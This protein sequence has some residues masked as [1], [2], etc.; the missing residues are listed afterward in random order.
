MFNLIAIA[1]RRLASLS[2]VVALSA[3]VTGPVLAQ[4]NPSNAFLYRV[5]LEL[6]SG[7]SAPGA[8]NA[9]PV[10]VTFSDLVVGNA[11]SVAVL[12][13]NSGAQALSIG[14]I[15]YAGGP[16]FIVDSSSCP[17]SLAAGQSCALG[18]T[19]APIARAIFNEA[20]LI[21]HSAG[22]TQVGL[23]GR[24]LQGALQASSANLS[25]DPVVVP[26]GSAST[27]QV[28]LTNVGDAAVGSITLNAEA[29][30]SIS[31]SCAT[32]GAGGTCDVSLQFSPTTA[33]SFSGA[34]Q[35]SSPVGNLSTGLSGQGVA[36]TSV[37]QLTGAAAIDF[38]A[39][40]LGASAV[41][42]T[43]SIRNDGNTGLSISGVSGL[44][45]SVSITSNS[46]TNV[47]PG[48][49]CA[50]VLTLS[51]A[52]M[53]S[54][55]NQAAQSVGASTN[56]SVSLTGSVTAS[57][58]TR[59]SG[60][61]VDFGSA[62]QNA[63][64]VDRT[65]TLRNDGNVPMTL[66]GISGLPGAVSVAS[67]GCSTVAPAAQCVIGLR[68]ATTGAI[69][70][71]SGTGTTQG[72]STNATVSVTGAITS[73][74]ADYTTLN[75]SWFSNR[76]VTSSINTAQEHAGNARFTIT[77]NGQTFTQS[78]YIRCGSDGCDANSYNDLFSEPSAGGMGH[79]GSSLLYQLRTAFPTWTISNVNAYTI[80]IN[81]PAGVSYTVS[82]S[83]FE[84]RYGTGANLS[85]NIGITESP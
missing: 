19:F 35:V 24:G 22:S 41:A 6:F 57:I 32:L 45:A 39:Q 42:R 69:G 60:A 59:V 63:A 7:Q 54:F 84:G 40:P 48:A 25:F 58:A 34:L 8:L 78:A 21:T 9:S 36:A 38:G 76:V 11:A 14:S 62:K 73:A 27:Q 66:T 33:G 56:A 31:G 20:I 13:E 74:I 46:C 55:S 3:V 79:S 71:V 2:A 65:I 53:A 75:F 1:A 47:A 17:D 44:P 26:G 85:G 37:A 49:T 81:P 5:P 18:V 68:M 83:A 52:Q 15:S 67:N 28:T 82:A 29:P 61:T 23:S 80:R 72:A 12:L 16:S 30:F 64:P 50:V 43:V 4:A 77:L 51:T 10:S 70:P